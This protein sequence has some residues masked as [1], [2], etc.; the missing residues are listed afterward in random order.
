V[1]S[2]RHVNEIGLVEEMKLEG[3]E[4]VRFVGPPVAYSDIENSAKSP[5]PLLGQHTREILSSVL[6]YSD[7][8][9]NQLFKNS[10]VQ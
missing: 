6:K 2:D 1:F 9:I 10:D 8:K 5:P 4:N 7:V 3:G